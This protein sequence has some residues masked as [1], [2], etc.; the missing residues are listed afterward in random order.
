MANS[1]LSGTEPRARPIWVLGYRYGNPVRERL[2][3]GD[4]GFHDCPSSIEP[5]RQGVRPSNRTVQPVRTR[6]GGCGVVEFGQEKGKQQP[7]VLVFLI[8]LQ[9]RGRRSWRST[10][11]ERAFR[12]SPR[13]AT[14]RRKP[15]F[16]TVL[17]LGAGCCAGTLVLSCLVVLLGL[18]LD[19]VLGY[20]TKHE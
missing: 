17:I 20:C 11:R 5:T 9:E 3:S 18:V 1:S 14:M 16:Y 12:L 6:L 7:R 15:R 13:T 10:D 2:R 4:D 8:S 19:L